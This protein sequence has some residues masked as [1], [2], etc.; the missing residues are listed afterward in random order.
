MKLLNNLL[1]KL[2]KSLVKN[3]VETFYSGKMEKN[4]GF[5]NK[6]FAAGR[7]YTPVNLIWLEELEKIIIKNKS[8]GKW[9][10]LGSGTGDFAVKLAENGWHVS[11]LDFS[12][13]AIQKAG[14]RAKEAGFSE[15]IDFVNVDLENKKWP[16]ALAGEK[17]DIV[18]AK[19]VWAFIKNK[20]NFLS[21]VKAV[22]KP[23]GFFVMTTPVLFS[24][25]FYD[26]KLKNI[27]SDFQKTLKLLNRKFPKTE[28]FSKNYFG[29]NGCEITFISRI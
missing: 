21:Y 27:S 25:F 4:S 13:I 26:K 7:D 24:G 23:R 20:E 29:E 12:K 17:F 22:L 5:W 6:N 11:A 14:L 10:D 8:S 16:K 19:L 28:I 9:L 1:I 2:R 3:L 15:K 18:S